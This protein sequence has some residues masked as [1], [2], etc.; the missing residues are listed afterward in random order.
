[1]SETA[2]PLWSLTASELSEGYGAGAF[3]P[4]DVA[5]ACLDRVARVNPLLNAVVTVDH[6]GALSA[7]RASTERWSRGAQLGPLDGV[8]ATVK[9]NLL[10]AGLRATWGSLVFADHIA[11]AD[12]TPVARLRASGAVIVGKTNTPEFALAGYTDNRVFGPTGNPWDAELSPGGSSGGAAAAIMSG[13]APLALTTDAGGSTRRPASHVG[14]IGLKPSLGRVPRRHGFPALATDFQ[15]VGVMARTIDD[16]RLLFEAIAAPPPIGMQRPA[17]LRIGALC[18]IGDAAVEPEIER[19]WTAACALLETIGHRVVVVEARF[20]PDEM[21]VLFAGLS[22]VGV[23]RMLAPMP[24][25]RDKVTPAI[26]DLA[27]RGIAAPAT[28]YV[29]CLDRVA[30][31]RESMADWFGGFDLLLTPTVAGP[32]WPKREAFP[33]VVAGCQATPRASAI[34]TTFANVAGLAG[35]SIPAGAFASGHPIGIQFVGPHGS[36]ELM[37]HVAAQ[38]AAKRPWPTL[39][40]IAA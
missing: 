35:L 15:S 31:F 12:E 6:D 2:A 25:W 27:E 36:E 20:D 4:D 26:L 5:R 3:T 16:T 24:D 13:M 1:M 11:A 10:V 19:A 8:P 37:L 30:A 34:F 33:K 22:S 39:A 40:P 7:A 38:F 32:L 21:G 18:R 23:A 17:T 29:S 28:A 14:C 9:D